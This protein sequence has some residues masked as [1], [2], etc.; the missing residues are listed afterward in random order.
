[1]I[2]KKQKNKT[3]RRFTTMK[4]CDFNSCSYARFGTCRVRQHKDRFVWS[5]IKQDKLKP[6]CKFATSHPFKSILS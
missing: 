3:K 1:M 2:L 4:N 5:Q 6:L